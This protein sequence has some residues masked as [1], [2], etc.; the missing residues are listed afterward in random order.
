MSESPPR[1][2][3]KWM[4]DAEQNKTPLSSWYML[5]DFDEQRMDEFL[6]A[7][8][9]VAIFLLMLVANLKVIKHITDTYF[10]GP[11]FPRFISI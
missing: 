4:A 9:V 2:L 7:L 1:S 10:P 8:F 6:I 5:A 11:T 3:K